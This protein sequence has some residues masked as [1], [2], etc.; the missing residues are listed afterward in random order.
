[1]NPITV[2]SGASWVLRCSFYDENNVAVVPTTITWTL[3]DSEGEIINGREDEAVAAL[4]TVYIH[5]GPLDNTA[6]E[7][8]DV[9]RVLRVEAKY[10]SVLMPGEELTIVEEATYYINPAEMPVSA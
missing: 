9:K 4:A 6:Y 7:G 8:D 2:N 5:L 10:G 1:M 3:T